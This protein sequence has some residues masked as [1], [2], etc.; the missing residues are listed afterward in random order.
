MPSAAA[1]LHTEPWAMLAVEAFS[2]RDTIC[3][4]T[5]A[6]CASACCVKPR[7]SRAVWM[8]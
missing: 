1:I 4:V 6:F 2:M 3:C 8:S 7:R 5:P